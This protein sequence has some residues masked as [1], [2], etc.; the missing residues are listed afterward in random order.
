MNKFFKLQE[1]G[2]TV[3]TE[4]MAGIITF[5][6]MAYII[7]VNPDMLSATGMDQG[8]VFTATILASVI[9]TLIMGLF[10]NF[11][12]A[13]APGMGM[14]AFFTFTVVLTMGYSWEQAL[15][16]I[17]VSGIL[18]MILSVTG[19]RELIINSIPTALKHAVGVGIGFFITFIGLV[20]AGIV[21]NN[22]AT[23]VGLGD[24][25]DPNVLLA[26]LGVIATLFLLVRKVP[27]AIFIGMIITT[28][29]GLLTGLIAVPTTVF[30]MPPSLT[31]TFCALFET[32]PSIFTLDMLPIIFSFL[33]VDFFDTAGTLISVGTNAGLIDKDGKLIDADKALLADSTATVIGSVL[34]TSSTTLFVESLAG[35]GAGGRTGLTAVVTAICFLAMLFFSPL[36][37]IVTSA[38]TA[39][40]LIAVGMLMASSLGHIEWDEIETTIPAFATI[41]V[42]LLGYSIAEG[43]AV[44][45]F[46]YPIMMLAAKRQKEVSPVMWALMV[47]FTIH[48]LI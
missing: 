25:T 1:R 39:P 17:F 12:V 3:K 26:L 6:S 45:F 23:L 24:F 30:S 9:G 2:T 43:I 22:D 36:L 15:A 28:I 42:M 19:L 18:F 5:L 46:L 13:L 38:V 14:N 10:A 27:A 4:V 48:F 16:G 8:A 35:V 47:I 44:G 37:G 41:I 20:N 31:P 34:G 21:V 33:F 7:F 11:P 29:A 40:A 32:L